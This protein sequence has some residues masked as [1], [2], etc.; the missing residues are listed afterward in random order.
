VTDRL[1]LFVDYQNIYRGAR[2]CFYP[3]A[4]IPN[5]A[6][7]ISP[8][9]LGEHIVTRDS[10]DRKLSGVRI[11]RGLPD[12][13][14]D[15]R[16]NAACTRQ[17]EAWSSDQRVA[18][19]TRALRY[20]RGWPD[21]CQPG[22]KPQEKGIDVALAID[23]VRLALENQYDVGV[24]MSTDSDL[25]PALETVAHFTDK[26]VEVAAWSG[27]GGHNQRLSIDNARLWCHWL[28]R[29]VYEQV[30]DTTNYSRP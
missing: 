18:V 1:M 12:A 5:V 16:G 27:R 29:N 11:Y 7:Q 23:F 19:I 28:H 3:E 13:T 24:L 30:C 22:E 26:R 9:R 4:G 2:D 8:V 20:P 25:R 21:R 10:F 6:G 15:S 14:R 17:I